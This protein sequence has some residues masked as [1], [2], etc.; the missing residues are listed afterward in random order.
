MHELFWFLAGGL[1]VW[2]MVWALEHGRLAREH[3]RRA[4]ALAVLRRQ[5]LCAQR[6]EPQHRADTPELREALAA[7]QGSGYLVLDA[8][9][10]LAGQLMP[11]SR[12]EPRL[13]VVPVED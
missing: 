3:R 10:R 13:R 2:V 1:S 6:Y 5:G 9:G 12:R 8:Q 7:Y 4:R 11:R